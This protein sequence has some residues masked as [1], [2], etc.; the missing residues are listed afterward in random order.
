MVNFVKRRLEWVKEATLNL[1]GGSVLCLKRVKF[2]DSFLLVV[3]LSSGDI[4]VTHLSLKRLSPEEEP[5]PIMSLVGK[6][7]ESHEFGVNSL[8]VKT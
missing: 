2:R 8:D 7:T 1:R 5:R 6:L 4:A 3:G